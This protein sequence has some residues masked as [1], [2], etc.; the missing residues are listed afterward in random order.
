MF[1]RAYQKIHQL[2][3]LYLPTFYPVLTRHQTIV[4]FI[5]S[6]GTAAFVQLGLLYVLTDFAGLWYL[7]SSTL[8]FIVALFI[9]FNLHKFWTF[10][11]NQLA[12]VNKQVF[13]YLALAIFNLGLNGLLMFVMVDFLNLWYMFA[14]IITGA[15]VAFWSFMIQ[16]K[17]IFGR[18]PKAI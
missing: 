7:A 1:R 4:K 14:Q 2:A 12:G 18:S 10:E 17:F 6:G 8:A 15:I 3:G 9:A 13:W 11:D 16:R 5:L